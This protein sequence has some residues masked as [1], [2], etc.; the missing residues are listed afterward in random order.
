MTDILSISCESVLMWIL[1]YLFFIIQHWIWQQT[2]FTAF[3][4]I[5]VFISKVLAEAIPK[6]ARKC[7]V[8][9]VSW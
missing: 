5:P 7:E 9:A 2:L 4:K 8:W 1:Q 6:L 3:L